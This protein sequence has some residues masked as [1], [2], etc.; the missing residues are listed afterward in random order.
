MSDLVMTSRPLLL[1][2]LKEVEPYVIFK[3]RHV[4]EA[5]RIIPMIRPRLTAEEFIK[6][7]HKA[8]AFSSLNYS[9]IEADNRRGC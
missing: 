3:K 6:V 7:V 4:A 9:K 2:V 5:L 8:D 1:T